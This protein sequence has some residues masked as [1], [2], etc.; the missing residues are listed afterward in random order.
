MT[1]FNVRLELL[2]TILKK[3]QKGEDVAIFEE[4]MTYQ[5]CPENQSNDE[6]IALAFEGQS[7][8]KTNTISQENS[9]ERNPPARASSQEPVTSNNEIHN[10]DK[11]NVSN[12]GEKINLDKIKMPP[13]MIKRG[14]PKGADTTVI[15]LPSSKKKKVGT[16]VPFSKLQPKEKNKQIMLWLTGDIEKTDKALDGVSLLSGNDVKPF[17]SLPD[18]LLDQCVDIYRVEKFFDKVGWKNVLSTIRKKEKTPWTC[19]VCSHKVKGAK[20]EES[21][22]CDRCLLWCHLNCT[23]LKQLPKRRN[24]FCKVCK[25]KYV[26]L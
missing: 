16:V 19:L 24:W 23:G 25:G 20:H 4:E 6:T 14:R 21:V 1:N 17:N 15:G 18:S 9:D 8:N 22:L 12:D 26:E 11:I 2:Q 3:W 13:K 10:F 5:E 7:I